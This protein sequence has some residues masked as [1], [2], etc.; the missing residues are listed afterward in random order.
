[1]PWMVVAAAG[2]AVIAGMMGSATSAADRAAAMAQH[3]AAVNAWMNVNIPDPEQQKIFLK[4]F[5]QTGTLSPEL[6]KQVKLDSTNYEKI[7]TNPKFKEATMRALG[8]MEDLGYS[9]GM[10]L[11]D[12]AN[13]QKLQ[14]DVDT[15]DRGRRDAIVDN[16]ARRGVGGS[17]FA[18]G[19]ELQGAQGSTNRLAQGSLDTAASAR[20]RAL[21]A[22]MGAGQLGGQMQAQDYN[23]QSNLAKARDSIQEYNARNLQSVNNRNVD[24]T[25]SANQYNLTN[26]QRISDANTALSNEQEKYNKGLIQ[27]NFQNQAAKAAGLSGQYNGV[28]N[29]Y[30]A[31]ADRTAN[32]WAGA[33]IGVGQAVSKYAAYKQSKP[34]DSGELADESNYKWDPYAENDKDNIWNYNQNA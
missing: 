6:E 21:D 27:Q 8:S 2:A 26:K 12:K 16:F 1:M 30:S 24:R 28:A 11:E 9:G 29:Q 20:K 10:T 17:G 4:Q 31:N 33:G 5:V 34:P 23:E 15:S 18:L 22:I 13:Q 14:N 32:Q 7:Q 19:A 3:Q 25:N